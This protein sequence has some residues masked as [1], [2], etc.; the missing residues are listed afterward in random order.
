MASGGRRVPTLLVSLLA[1]ASLHCGEPLVV[2]I[3]D[4]APDDFVCSERARIPVA[5]GFSRALDPATLV[6]NALLV[7][8][9]DETP[10]TTDVGL[11]FAATA[12]GATAE[13]PMSSE[14]RTFLSV[15]VDADGDGTSED[16]ATVTF[17]F[18]LDA[19]CEAEGGVT[20]R[21]VAGTLGL[22]YQR[23][24]SPSFAAVAQARSDSQSG[25]P[26]SFFD[27]TGLPAFVHGL[28]G[29]ALL[30]HDRDG[31]LDIYV[32]NGP[33]AANSL[34]SSLLAET[35]SLAFL[36]VA[37]AAG[38]AATDQDSSGVCFGDVDNDGDE[39]L[40]VL[41]VGEPNRLFENQGGSFTDVT[42]GS[43]LGASSLTSTSCAMG[44]VNG[45]GLLDVAVANAA[46]F[47]TSLAFFVLPFSLNHANELFLNRGDGEFEDVSETSGI[48]TLNGLPAGVAS[49]TWAVSLVDVDLDGD[50]DL[51]FADDQGGLPLTRDGGTDRGYV[52]VF[53]NDGAG[54]FTGVPI[55][56]DAVSSGQ[57]MG[58][59]FGDLDC[60]GSLDTFVTNF[61]DYD[62][63]AL[64]FPY[65]LGDLASRWFLG[66][67]GG[68]FTDPKVGDLVATP[69]G[70]GA[71]VFDYDNDGDGDVVYHGGIDANAIFGADNPGVLLRN[72]GCT[73]DFTWEA[74]A[75]P[76]TDHTRRNVRGLALGDLD[77]NGFVDVVSVSSA[78]APAE[79]SLSASPAIHGS[80]FD[81]TALFVPVFAPT[82]LGLVW[83]GI[84]MD[85]GTLSVE[86]S[87]AGNRN[88][89]VGVGVRGSVGLTAL[90]RVNR[91]G[92]GAVVSFT[93]NGGRTRIRPVQGGSSHAS[94]HALDG[95]FGL[96]LAP[97]GR[98][99]VLWPGG[100][101]NR[102]YD[103][104][105]GERVV[106]PE[107]PCS[108]D[109]PWPD[110]A[111]YLTCVARAL[112]DLVTGAQLTTAQATRLLLSAVR[113]FREES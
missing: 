97:R 11:L 7:E 28:P 30:D 105:S 19:D 101:R 58:L 5:L 22:D 36:D 65:L 48:R 20:F 23:V 91:D 41:G 12:M 107:I 18:E 79:V 13:I 45:D 89:W 53:H 68:G 50:A 54:N 47:S 29:V 106:V 42:Q 39:D 25:S 103:V 108:F 77:D 34:Y 74:G 1:A 111:A 43:G 98:V 56:A 64:G 10:V 32:T 57:W 15:N 94:Q 2:A 99:E 14:G 35:G 63:P 27:L 24:R 85:P 31:D 75:F 49:I 51:V 46:D 37:G 104:A 102:L 4:P 76:T 9:V 96:G 52:H 21:D 88:G 73:A 93:P 69:F 100:V 87:D 109:A 62:V 78:D 6:L 38:A 80:P 113:A 112:D 59:G 90:G 110:E 70:W 60:S 84:D 33:G 83:T 92:I 40:L 17:D 82:V 44:D 72:E 8:D 55:Q 71:G 81:A 67:A 3:N 26:L 86:L 16:F 61:G 95:R 66:A